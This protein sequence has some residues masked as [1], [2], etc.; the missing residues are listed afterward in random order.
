MF[1]PQRIFL[2]FDPCL[3]RLILYIV[4][5]FILFTFQ[6]RSLIKRKKER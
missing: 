6:S 4:Q 3:L 5:N 2:M 1:G